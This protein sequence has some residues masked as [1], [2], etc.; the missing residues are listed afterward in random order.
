MYRWLA[1][2]LLL[3]TT[4]A[5]ARDDGEAA[6]EP[7]FRV[8]DVVLHTG[9]RELA[10][11]QIELQYDPDHVRIVG[12]EGDPR[13][14]YYDRR[15]LSA[16]RIVIASFTTARDDLARGKVRLC[17]LHIRLTAADSPPPT[18]RLITAATG[19][20]AKFTAR[21]DISPQRAGEEQ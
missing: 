20:G 14:P 5:R 4:A 11:W 1:A 15:G 18:A 16:G 10:A 2:L 3:T 19:T 6:D 7:R 13:P 12:I 17:R 8:Y 9:D 21:L